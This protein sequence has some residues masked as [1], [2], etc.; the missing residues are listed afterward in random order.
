MCINR[1]T[2][3][4]SLLLLAV[5]F[6]G[7]GRGVRARDD[8]REAQ[9]PLDISP[10]GQVDRIAH[11]QRGPGEGQRTDSGS[12]GLRTGRTGDALR[13]RSLKERDEAG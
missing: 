5:S 13:R 9:T 2:K 12:S 11:S 7:L 3:T 8:E 1:T 4:I 6:E 10:S